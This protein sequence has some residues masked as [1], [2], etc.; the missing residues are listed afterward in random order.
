VSLTISSIRRRKSL[1]CHRYHTLCHFYLAPDDL[2]QRLSAYI[3][4]EGRSEMWSNS[5]FFNSKQKWRKGVFRT[6]FIIWLQTSFISS[7][8][9]KSPACLLRYMQPCRLPCGAGEAIWRPC[10]SSDSCQSPATLQA[11]FRMQGVTFHS[12]RQLLGG[13]TLISSSTS[14]PT[15]CLSL[16]PFHTSPLHPRTTTFYVT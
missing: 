13:Q 4:N 16:N 7:Y 10:F 12:R 1:V 3:I 11:E 14:P 15:S 5:N 9:Q 2:S 8:I 6:S